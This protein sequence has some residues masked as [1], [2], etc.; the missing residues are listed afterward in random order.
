VACLRSLAALGLPTR[1]VIIGSD[2]SPP[3]IR[4]LVLGLAGRRM[5]AQACLQRHDRLATRV[6]AR[7][8]GCSTGERYQ[9]TANRRM[10]WPDSAAATRGERKREGAFARVRFMQAL[11]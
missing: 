2:A 6:R 3:V 7:L 11:V 5:A 1:D 10:K 4:S 9:G 8:L